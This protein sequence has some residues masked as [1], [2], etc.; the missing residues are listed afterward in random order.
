MTQAEQDP[1]RLLKTF[2]DVGVQL[3]QTLDIDV[4]LTS[5]VERAMETT[6]AP[7][8]AAVTVDEM[9]AVD[10]FLHRGLTPEQVSM[11]PH[12]PEG[13]GLL[14]LV[15]ND[16]RAVRVNDIAEHP[17]SIGFPLNHVA[18]KAFLGVPMIHRGRL[19]GAIYLTKPPD[20]PAFTDLDQDFV[21]TMAA[22]AAVGVSNALLFAAETERAERTVLLA[23]IS[24]DIRRSLD[25][26][27]VLGTTVETLARATEV[28]RCFIRLVAEPASSMLGE[29]AHEWH[30]PDV[31]GISHEHDRQYPVSSL[32]AMSRTTQWS[33]DV[34]KDERLLDPSILGEPND[35]EDAQ[36]RAV[37]STPLA[38]GDELLGVVTLHSRGPRQWGRSDIALIEAAAQEVSI[39][40]H[41]ARLY[42][43]AMDST[44][45]LQEVD[46]MRSDFIQMVSHELRSPMTVVSGISEILSSRGERL[47]A[48]QRIELV[49]TL[50]RE[51]RRLTR[52]VSQVLDLEA[53]DRGGFPLQAE[54]VDLGAIAEEA[55]TDSGSAERTTLMVGAGERIASVD[56]DR[57]KQVLLN[58]IG[59]AAKFS[60]PSS[61]ITVA[62]VPEA[63]EV[64]VSVADRGP[65]IAVE[66]QVRLFRRFSRLPA[67]MQMKPGSGLGLYLSRKIVEEHGGAIWVESQLGNGATF[68][69]R[70][71]RRPR[72]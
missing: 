55:V 50:G 71:P 39:A 31:G 49:E 4:V 59:N 25:L 5:I 14:G 21:E 38:W 66:D 60:D 58:L 23:E 16:R 43:D 22:F 62:V 51:A 11:L 30:A 7:Y 8:G 64:V 70:V 3:T 63:D 48:E 1:R 42:G 19:V 10:N 54:D 33:A 56:R 24:A 36:V 15:L 20:H 2:L 67:T 53:V 28:D 61:P 18:M 69:F 44:R 40:L 47:S 72:S 57:I 52:L 9:A 46:R 41:H 26:A 17:D 65:G 37:L 29:I 45:K 27:D 32:A 34:T 35:L 6:G 68:S 13:K 12:Y